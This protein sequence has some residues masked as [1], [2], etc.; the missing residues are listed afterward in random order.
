MSQSARVSEMSLSMGRASLWL[1]AAGFLLIAL[2]TGILSWFPTYG[3]LEF[4]LQSLGPLAIA[5]AVALGWRTHVARW[6]WAAF[7]LFL[8]GILAYG[9]MWFAYAVDP[10]SLG[11]PSA[12]QRGFFTVGVGYLCAAIGMFLVMGRKRRQATRAGASAVPQIE[13]TFTQM[14]IF[15]LGALVCA[16]GAFIWLIPTES[17]LQHFS[18]LIIGWALVLF[19]SIAARKGLAANVGGPATVM[20]I[21]AV[22]AYWLHYVLDALPAWMDSDWRQSMHVSGAAFVF[23]AIAFVIMATRQRSVSTQRKAVL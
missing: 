5:L 14:L 1:A 4:A 18:L 10:G 9:V 7:L 21:L 6:G 15:S 11:D 12:T 16:A 20:I 13:A 2:G 23:A 17:K 8:A 3:T 22:F 19:S